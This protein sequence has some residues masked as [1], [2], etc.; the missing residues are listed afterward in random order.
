MRDDVLCVAGVD[1]GD[2]YYGEIQR[3]DF[4]RHDGLKT[5]NGGCSLDYWVVAAVGG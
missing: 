4:A 3:V 2:C 1:R 5:E